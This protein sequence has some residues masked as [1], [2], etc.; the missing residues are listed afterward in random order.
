M[1]EIAACAG[2]VAY[3]IAG[4]AIMWRLMPILSPDEEDE[5]S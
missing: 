2:F 5:E 3:V 4:F 1:W